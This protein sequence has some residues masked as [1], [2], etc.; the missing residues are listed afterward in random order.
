LNTIPGQVKQV[1]IE[2]IN[3]DFSSSSSL[4]TSYENKDIIPESNDEQRVSA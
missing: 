4:K 2:N 3:D 1:Q